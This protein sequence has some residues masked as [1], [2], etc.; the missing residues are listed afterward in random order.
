MSFELFIQKNQSKQTII[1]AHAD[2][3]MPSSIFFNMTFYVI[4]ATV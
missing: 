2:D 3:L 4:M 1:Q